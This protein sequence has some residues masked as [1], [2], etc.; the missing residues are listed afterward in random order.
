MINLTPTIGIT[1]SDTSGQRSV[2]VKNVPA[3]ST[4]GELLDVLM[5]R[6]NLGSAG[7]NG[8]RLP[9]AARLDREGRHLNRSELVR[10]ALRDQDHIVLHPQIMAGSGA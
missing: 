10:D 6:M 1:A 8:N 4:V 5:P 3:D 2:R 7:A 9:M